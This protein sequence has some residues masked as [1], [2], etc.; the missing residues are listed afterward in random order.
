MAWLSTLWFTVVLL[1]MPIAF[2]LGF[3]TMVYIW[4]TGMPLVVIPQRMVG[5]IDSFPLL[6]VPFFILAANL[7]NS[8][9]I[10]DRLFRFAH[11]IVGSVRGGLAHVN[12]VASIIFSGMS[13]SAVADA[14]GL[15][16]ME[17]RAMREAGYKPAF[18]AAVTV[19]SCI[20]GPLIPPSIPLVIYGVLAD[21]SIGRLFL[22]GVVP[23]VITGGAL[24]IM[25]SFL[26]RR[27]NLPIS[28]PVTRREAMIAGR[29]AI[30]PLM[31]PVI[32]I[33]GIAW[34]V[35]SPTEA[36]AAASLYALILGTVIYR[37]LDAARIFT[38]LLDTGRMTA[39]ICL[40]VATATAFAWLLTA[41]Q[42]PQQTAAWLVS[43]SD[44][45]LMLLIIINV[46]VFIAAFFIEGLAIMILVVPVMMPT[47]ASV[48]I[49]PV[50][51]GVVLVFNLMI[52][53]M[54]PP[55]GVGLF[56][57][58]SVSNI[59]VEAIAREVIVFLVPL[60][61]VLG[62][63]IAFPSLVTGLPDYVLG[64]SR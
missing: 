25:I 3:A 5:G 42:I 12:V 32:I 44:D 28:E 52:G 8:A 50:H 30:L 64:P 48:G 62:L 36:S 63:L 34:G 43:I 60:L 15:G 27:R 9:G 6:A 14:G 49:D 2:T 41:L 1:G 56:V 38:V 47:M 10:T 39:S 20:V 57:V 59:R 19:A 21:A 46:V 22:G 31:T 24:M 7:M 29:K 16:S 11:M 35:F 45:P 4:W 26:A 58:S 37:E 18:A 33:G 23:G 61:V 53:L 55:M 13:G 54:T 40:I 17:I 51:F